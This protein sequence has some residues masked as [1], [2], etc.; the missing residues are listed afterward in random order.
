MQL[1][2]E[3]RKVITWN[4]FIRTKPKYSI[5]LDG[6]VYGAPKFKSQS[7]ELFLSFDPS[8]KKPFTE[9][10]RK[11]D[12][13]TVLEHRA[14]ASLG[15]AGSKFPSEF[16]QK[17][18]GSYSPTSWSLEETQ[19]KIQSLQ[20]ELI[21]GPYAN[22]NHHEEVDRLATRSTSGQVHLAIKQG[23][24]DS[25]RPNG[26]V[27]GNIYVNDPDQDTCTAYWLLKN[28]ER[29]EGK[30]SEPL[31]NRLVH[32]EDL[33]DCT[34]GAYPFDPL[35]KLM[36]ELAW[37]YEPYTNARVSNRVQK[38]DEYEMRSVMEAVSGRI[39]KHVL[40]Q[41]EEVTPDLRYERIGGG[42]NWA[43]VKEIG[44]QA[45]TKLFA[46]GIKAFVAVRDNNNGT[47]IY[48]IGRMSPYIPFPVDEL[49][50]Y[51]N[52][53]EGISADATDK[54]GGGNTI[55]GSPRKAGSKQLPTE[56]EKNINDYLKTK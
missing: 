14:R 53:I 10:E 5:A 31:I 45:R 28:Y 29:I 27:E 18:I 6:Y 22:F 30:K 56:L 37:V 32:A 7:E 44:A 38:M 43:M 52:K 51:L 41:G 46:D 24:M 9:E 26:R 40:G 15:E 20:A 17:A 1:H 12:L 25:F 8:L 36:R 54:W 3:P 47:Y 2:I 11:L 48:S 39:S 19:E 34:A 42:N 4:E 49:P 33:Q 55:I 23:L 50:D 13:L 16:Y 35:S 21:G